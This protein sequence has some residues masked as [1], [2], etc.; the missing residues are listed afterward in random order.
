[1]VVEV[2]VPLSG[3]SEAMVTSVE[4]CDVNTSQR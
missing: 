4:Y 1:V 3:S 2:R